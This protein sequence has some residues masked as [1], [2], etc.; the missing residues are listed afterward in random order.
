MQDD[1]KPAGEKEVNPAGEK[2]ER[3]YEPAPV[4][5]DVHAEG[6]LARLIE[7]QTAKLPS[8]FFL[9]CALGS[10]GVSLYLEYSGRHQRSRFVG[11]WATPLLVMGVY[12]KLI[13]LMGTR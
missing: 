5:R 11:M 9:W 4:V 6:M 10:M 8:D 13:K 3:A 1:E 7:Q 2:S 12:D